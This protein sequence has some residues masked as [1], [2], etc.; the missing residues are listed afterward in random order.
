MNMIIR[1]LRVVPA[2][3]FS[4]LLLSAGI[5]AHAAPPQKTQKPKLVLFM[6]IDQFRADY[7][8]R[9]KNQFK[10]AKGPGGSVGGFQYLMTE[11]AYY[12]YAEYD[13]LQCMT[14]PGHATVLSGA[15]P[16]QMGIPVNDWFDRPT[17]QRMYCTEDPGAKT[18]G[19][20]STRPHV[21]TSPKNFLGSTVGDELKNSGYPSRVVSL[22]LKDRAAI[23]MGGHR[24][25]LAVWLDQEAFQWVSSDYYLPGGKLPD[26][27]GKLNAALSQDKGKSITWSVEGK[28]SGL[29][30]T[31]P[32]ILKDAHN[33]AIGAGF[34]HTVKSASKESL[35]LPYGLQITE[36]LAEKALEEYGLG[37]GPAT[38]LL[39]VSFSSHDY[40]AHAFG[41]NS[42]EMEE[43]T[44]ADDQNISKLLNFVNRSV[45]GGLKNVVIVLTADHGGVNNPDYLAANKMNAG[46]VDE[47]AILRTAEAELVKKFGK[48]EGNEKW[49]PY[50]AD[51]NFHFNS[52]AIQ[53]KELKAAELENVLREI[54][55]KTIGIAHVF[56]ATDHQQRK[57]PPGM[58]QRQILKTYYPGRSGDV[59]G[60]LMPNFITLGDTA[61]H[62]T[63]YAYDRTVP[64]VLAGAPFKA[65]QYAQK[66]EVIDIAPTLTYLLGTMPPTLSE[67]RVLSEALK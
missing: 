52:R 26:W 55:L 27:L 38:D 25:D 64:L 15:Y 50:V 67:G 66:A 35:R 47:A 59:I 43:M 48:L 49:I 6:V 30:V 19:V 10:P 40:L 42:R 60:M 24:A 32:L 57:L 21:G 53:K 29:S 62:M 37:S 51:L 46:R 45:P 22:A 16:Y 3:V 58:H 11:G 23:L 18:L 2:A 8:M 28:G 61:S 33:Q 4:L 41:P 12:P 36:A 56:T 31:D 39:A 7:L 54:L 1:S 20:A 9:F 14:G 65:G 34:P 5:P 13:L 44:L 63:G 17:Q